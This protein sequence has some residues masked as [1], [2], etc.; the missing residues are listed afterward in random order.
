[1]PIKTTTR[2][3]APHLHPPTRKEL[4]SV[5]TGRSPS[6]TLE[7]GS[8]DAAEAGLKKLEAEHAQATN[9]LHSVVS[10]FA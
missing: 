9:E 4:G 8:L 2:I 7:A 1:M 6:S 3:C 5:P 10:I